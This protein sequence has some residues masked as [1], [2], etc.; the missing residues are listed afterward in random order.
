VAD[1]DAQALISFVA[2]RDVSC[3]VCAY[4]LRGLEAPVCPECAAPLHLQVGSDNLR[5][6]PWFLA[7]VSLAL[8]LGFDGVVSLM[9]IIAMIRF[10]PTRGQA[11]PP[12]LL[13]LF[14]VPLGTVSAVGLWQMF[15]RRMQWTRMP[16]PRQKVR[17]AL[18]FVVTG[19]VHGVAGLCLI[20]IFS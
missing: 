3:P 7:V 1:S 2:A 4:N 9:V 12:I 15:A 13:L 8:A 20:K 14:L 17:A 6:G 11:W 18:I 5:L 10:A 16:R 19:V